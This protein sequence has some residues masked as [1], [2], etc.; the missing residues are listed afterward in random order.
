MEKSGG[1]YGDHHVVGRSC[2]GEVADAEMLP[3]S[4][5]GLNRVL[6]VESGKSVS[7][8]LN[9]SK[10]GDKNLCGRICDL[11]LVRKVIDFFK[12][13]FRSEQVVESGCDE[14]CNNNC[15]RKRK[16]IVPVTASKHGRCDVCL[17]RQIYTLKAM[18]GLAKDIIAKVLSV[19]D[20]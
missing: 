11:W 6:S 9:Q 8:T 19:D 4:A 17:W 15:N 1:I 20:L 12:D 5:N 16:M 13:L 18:C 7:A 10:T 2:V 14:I 3:G